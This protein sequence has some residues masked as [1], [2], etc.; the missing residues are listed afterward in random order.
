MIYC[1]NPD[2]NGCRAAFTAATMDKRNERKPAKL[3][4]DVD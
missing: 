1:P 3:T 4:R 2:Y